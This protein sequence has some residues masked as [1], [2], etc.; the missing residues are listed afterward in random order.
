MAV[1]G[2]ST[3]RIKHYMKAGFGQSAINTMMFKV[4]LRQSNMVFRLD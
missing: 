1:L 3:I 2:Q 4:G